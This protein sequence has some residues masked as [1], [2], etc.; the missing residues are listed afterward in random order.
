MRIAHR[1][2]PKCSG[3]YAQKVGQVHVD[4]ESAFEG[5]LVDPDRPRSGHIDWLILCEDCVRTAYR[6][7]PENVEDRQNLLGRIAQ[8]EDDAREAREYADNLRKTLRKTLDYEQPTVTE[9]VRNGNPV[10]KPQP[11]PQPAP[12]GA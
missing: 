9:T 12:Q 5:P 2:P 6:M 10:G 3:C 7:L 8:L 1:V 4:F 11:T